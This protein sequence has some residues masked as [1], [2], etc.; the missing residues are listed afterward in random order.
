MRRQPEEVGCGTLVVEGD[1]QMRVSVDNGVRRVVSRWQGGN[2]HF[3][4][5]NFLTDWTDSGRQ[6]SCRVFQSTDSGVK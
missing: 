1:L 4:A 2:S 5:A 6:C 3:F